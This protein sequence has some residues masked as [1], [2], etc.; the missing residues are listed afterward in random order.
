MILVVG[1]TG[2]LGWEICKK[3]AA[4]GKPVRALVRPDSNPETVAA[5][6]KLGVETVLG[7]LTDKGSLAAACKGV[8]AVISTATSVGMR[9]E[10]DSFETV[11]RQGQLDL[12][13]A[14]EQADATQFIYLSFPPFAGDFPLQTAKRAVEARL[15]ASSLAHTVLQPPHFREGWLTAP[16][17]VNPETGALKTCGGGAGAISWIALED[18]RDAVCASVDRP[19]AY[20]KIL[21]IG[22]DEAVS[23]SDIIAR[24]EH[25]AGRSLE[26]EDTPRA[27]LEDMAASGDPLLSTF[28]GLMLV[29][30]ED[31]CVI[32]DSDAREI[33]DF[34][35]RP[36]SGFLEQLAADLSKS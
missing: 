2:V 19:A 31:G 32:D 30:S 8:K 20:N 6:S 12:I 18:V 3:L 13:E 24:C 27:A 28:A 9:K 11:D 35:P 26:R 34:A 7:D 5:L 4:S 1:A 16:L 22:G 33:L 10:S 21:Q 25:L 23:Q 36:L 14:A 17:G 15:E 29:C